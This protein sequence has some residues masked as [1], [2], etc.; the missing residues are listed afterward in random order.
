MYKSSP[1]AGIEQA[2][3]ELV[4]RLRARR[5]EIE[6]G[7]ATSVY[8]LADPTEVLDPDYLDGLRAS[9]ASAID[10]ALNSI[11][12][13]ERRSPPIPPA[14][15]VQARLAAR[16]NVSLATVLRRYFAGYVQISQFTFEEIEAADL[17]GDPGLR[18]LLSGQ[19]SVFDRLIAEITAEY[20]REA[21]SQAKSAGQRRM[22]R[23]CRLLAGEA[24]DCTDL[25]YD[26][27][28]WHVG[29]VAGGEGVEGIRLLARDLGKRLLLARRDEGTVWAWLG[30]RDPSDPVELEMRIGTAWPE[31][32]ALAIGEPAR[33]GAGWRLTHRQAAT[34]FPLARRR[35]QFVRYSDVALIATTLRDDL[36]ATSLHQLYLAPLEADRDGGKAH[37]ETLRAYMRAGGNISAASAALGVGRATVKNR[38]QTIETRLGRYLDSCLAEIEVALR[39]E[40]LNHQGGADQDEGAAPARQ[41]LLT[42]PSSSNL[43]RAPEL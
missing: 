15:A 35:G 28:D 17:L 16:C 7:I 26:L 20:S 3:A 14:L 11:E 18:E 39:L 25:G 2:R 40:E 34:A 38:L 4:A 5:A 37:R 13:G 19:A 9:L 42:R 29:V 8:S 12:L 41:Q 6:G 27:D 43:G 36:L 32:A 10:Y 33:G 30:S 23:I 22:E 24:I 21:A 1:Q 31:G